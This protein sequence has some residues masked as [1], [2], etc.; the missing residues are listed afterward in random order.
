MTDRDFRAHVIQLCDYLEDSKS[1]GSGTLTDWPTIYA[2][3]QQVR[4]FAFDQ[5]NDLHL[6]S[7]KSNKETENDT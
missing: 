1:D 6:Q 4:S 2:K 5:L 3:A 7:H